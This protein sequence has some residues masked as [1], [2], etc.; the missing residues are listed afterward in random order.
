LCAD[1]WAKP[2]C[3]AT[4]L[5]LPT[6]RHALQV[7]VTGLLLVPQRPPI[8]AESSSRMSG[9]SMLPVMA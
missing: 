6:R 7:E 8:A 2:R 4:A 5:H 1:R 3:S 9:S